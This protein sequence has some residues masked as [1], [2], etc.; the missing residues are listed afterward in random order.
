MVKVRKRKDNN[1]GLQLLLLMFKFPW[2]RYCF[3]L[4]CFGIYNKKKDNRFLGIL[5]PRNYSK[6]LVSPLL[7]VSI[8]NL[9]VASGIGSWILSDLSEHLCFCY[10]LIAWSLARQI[11]L[12]SWPPDS[13]NLCMVRKKQKVWEFR[14]MQSVKGGGHV[15]TIPRSVWKLTFPW[16][17]FFHWISPQM[18]L[19][20]TNTVMVENVAS[21]VWQ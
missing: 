21:E 5:F 17:A 19:C 20:L 12:W 1:L 4:T 8:P 6:K 18:T 7:I 11:H 10:K 2:I 16:V 9:P 15:C 3:Y 14:K 13:L